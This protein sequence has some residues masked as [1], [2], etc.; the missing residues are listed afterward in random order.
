MAGSTA[1]NGAAFCS[2]TEQESCTHQEV[3]ELRRQ[4]NADA[5]DLRS[6]ISCNFATPSLNTGQLHVHAQVAQVTTMQR[7]AQLQSK[8]AEMSK[9]VADLRQQL[10]AIAQ[11]KEAV[12][13]HKQKRAAERVKRRPEHNLALKV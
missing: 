9:E 2:A 1:E 13:A 4:L 12:A 5:Q 3:A 7:F 8:N 10:N 11:E 6:K